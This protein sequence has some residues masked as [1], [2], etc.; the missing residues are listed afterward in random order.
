MIQSSLVL[1]HMSQS[2]FSLSTLFL[3]Y[4]TQSPF[5]YSALSL[6]HIGFNQF[7]IMPIFL[8]LS[9]FNLRWFQSTCSS[10]HFFYHPLFLVDVVLVLVQQLWYL[11][12]CL[13]SFQSVSILVRISESPF[14]QSM[15]LFV[16]ISFSP[17]VVMPIFLVPL[18]LSYIVLKNWFR[19]INNAT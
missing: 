17:H 10:V 14:S 5:F 1:V 16:Y 13:H 19:L 8:V 7:V 6:M 4:I 2:P 12:F 11:R 9:I 3:A 18:F 15:L